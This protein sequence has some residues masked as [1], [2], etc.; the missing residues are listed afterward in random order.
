ML[1]RGR[2]QPSSRGFPGSEPNSG[3]GDHSPGYAARGW[4]LPGCDGAVFVL[5]FV[6]LAIVLALNGVKC[7]ST[8]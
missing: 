2:H 6:A 8:K 1:A 3:Q 4:V 7:Y 5:V